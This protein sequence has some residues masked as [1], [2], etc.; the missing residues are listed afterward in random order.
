MEEALEPADRAVAAKSIPSFVHWTSRGGS[1]SV[2]QQMFLFFGRVAVYNTVTGMC[3]CR[4]SLIPSIEPK[5]R[6]RV[7]D[8]LNSQL[9]MCSEPSFSWDNIC[10][11]Y[12]QHAQ[13]YNKGIHSQLIEQRE[14]GGKWVRQCPETAIYPTTPCP[15]QRQHK[16]VELLTTRAREAETCCCGEI[17]H[18]SRRRRTTQTSK[19]EYVYVAQ[20]TIRKRSR[21]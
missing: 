2:N 1:C 4:T 16:P 9:G 6:A 18:Q 3:L 7:L 19:R 17:K 13:S 5:R 21:L 15:S 20:V 11:F 12:L 14:N 10:F 8:L